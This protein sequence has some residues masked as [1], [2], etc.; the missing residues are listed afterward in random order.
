M[1]TL[2]LLIL[3]VGIAFL[4]FIVKQMINHWLRPPERER[5]YREI[6]AEERAIEREAGSNIPECPICGSPTR[7]HR[8]PHITVWRCQKYPECRGFEK[9]RKPKRLKFASDWDRKRKKSD[10]R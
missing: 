1:S 10:L 6:D 4:W 5:E 9:A 3:L 2:R 8:Y 7:L